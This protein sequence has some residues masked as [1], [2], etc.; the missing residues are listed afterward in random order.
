MGMFYVEPWYFASGGQEYYSLQVA[1]GLLDHYAMTSMTQ[2]NGNGENQ[3][4]SLR[5]KKQLTFDGDTDK[6]DAEWAQALEA[7][8]SEPGVGAVT[9]NS[10]VLNSYEDEGVA[11]FAHKRFKPYEIYTEAGYL[12]YQ[13]KNGIHY[14]D[15]PYQDVTLERLFG[16]NI[17]VTLELY[18]Q[19]RTGFA[20]FGGSVNTP[21][22]EFLDFA[23]QL[24]IQGDVMGHFLTL[25]VGYSFV[26]YQTAY[27][28]QSG[29]LVATFNM[30]WGNTPIF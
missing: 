14:G 16:R 4:T 15:G 17:G 19:Q 23:P 1:M 29:I 13:P 2:Y 22:Y 5:L 28:L 18:N 21:G 6:F 3:R 7:K 20:V 12:F 8:I 24:E 30:F 25:G 10:I 11:Y 26:A 9:Q 27:A